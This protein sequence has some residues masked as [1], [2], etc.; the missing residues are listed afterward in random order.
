M[1]DIKLKQIAR[2]VR[3]IIFH[4]VKKKH[5]SISQKVIPRI[6]PHLSP[7]YVSINSKMIININL[8]C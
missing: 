2:Y 1:T 8:K 3:G 4:K 7:N 6:L 5:E